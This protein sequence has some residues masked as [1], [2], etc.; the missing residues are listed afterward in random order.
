M[1]PI[2]IVIP[3]LKARARFLEDRCLPS[4][5]EN[6]PA[7]IVIEG[8][9][10]SA[11]VKRNAGAAK[12]R[13]PYIYFVDDD[14]IM[15]TG[16]LLK[17]LQALEKDPGAAFA[18]S[19]TEMV[20]Y[21]GVPYPNPGGIRKARPW[22]YEAL[23]HGNYVESMS[24]FRRKEFP[25]FDPMIKRFQD[26]DLFLSMGAAGKYG[27]YVPEVLFELHHFDVGISAGQPFAENVRVIKEKHG[28]LW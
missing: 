3:H 5:L 27:A 10:E 26:W 12:I 24:L 7:Q 9:D 23:K 11:P 21:P 4:V 15:R 18:Y 13:E 19:D 2:G 16:C 6:N 25:G 28:L 14:S 17:L 22:D 1:L 8:G 20:L